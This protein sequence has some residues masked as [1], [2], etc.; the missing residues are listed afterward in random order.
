MKVGKLIE[1]LVWSMQKK[2]DGQE[3]IVHAEAGVGTDMSE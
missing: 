1:K 2:C 3:D